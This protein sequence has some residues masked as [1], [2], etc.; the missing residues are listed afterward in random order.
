LDPDRRDKLATLDPI[1]SYLL[2]ALRLGR[3]IDG[4]VDAYYGP[5][6][7]A[8]RVESE[9]MRAPAALV[10]DAEELAAELD[11]ALDPQRRRWIEAQVRGMHTVASRLAGADMSY[12]DE[13]E[14]TYGVRPAFTPEE[15]FAAAH[16]ELDRLLP[17]DGT[18]TERY[19]AW[20]EGDG[21]PTD[22]LAAAFDG[23]CAELRGRTEAALGLPVGETIDVELVQDVPWA[24]FN[25][26]EGALRSRIAVSTDLSV[27]AVFIGQLAAHETY[28]GH[29]TEHAWKERLFLLDRGF[30]EASVI[31]TGAPESL[32]SEGIAEVGGELVLG[33]GGVQRLAA[34]VLAEHGV[35][36]D[37]ELADR[38]WAAVEGIEGAGVNVALLVHEQGASDEDAVEY[39]MR[40]ALRSRKHAEKSLSFI[41]DPTWRA[42]VSTYTDGRRLCRAYVDDDLGRFRRLLT[43]QVTT[44]DLTR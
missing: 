11:G 18:L 33:P 31:V 36:L 15:R 43:E 27:P 35:E 30:L 22:V 14:H 37:A 29:H 32:V 9:E 25:Y 5:P 28:P 2:L 40:W 4:F 42:Y 6:E 12:S 3:H 16:E 39:L 44:A 19:Q 20:R 41:K 34:E 8:T 10:A 21:V 17:G 1:E 23:I 38:V 26:Y 7:P 24:A 13:V